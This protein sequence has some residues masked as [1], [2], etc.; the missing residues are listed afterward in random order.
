MEY[1][2]KIFEEYFQIPESKKGTGLGLY[3]VKKVV[4]NHKGNVV[5]H[6]ELNKGASF[7]ITLPSE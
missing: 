7:E 4:E 3:S 6:S 2:E 5:L 1:H